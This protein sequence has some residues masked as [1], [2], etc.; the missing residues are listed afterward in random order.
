MNFNVWHHCCLNCSG[1]EH[2]PCQHLRRKSHLQLFENSCGYVN[3]VNA[4]ELN[5]LWPHPCWKCW[6]WAV[7]Y[8]ELFQLLPE[9][10]EPGPGHLQKQLRVSFPMQESSLKTPFL[11]QNAHKFCI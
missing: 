6:G 9:E 1:T 4:L 10:E 7:C 8:M 5:I 11:P 2:K 3:G